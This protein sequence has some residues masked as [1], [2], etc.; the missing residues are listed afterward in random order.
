M[1][2]S[3]GREYREVLKCPRLQSFAKRAMR[4]SRADGALTPEEVA[5][6]VAALHV[7]SRQF[8]DRQEQLRHWTA[9]GLAIMTD[10]CHWQ[11]VE[12]A[13]KRGF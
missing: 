13:R 3:S 9:K 2:R 5:V 8:M 12:L 6:Y 10:A 1:V 4:F 11:V 7:P